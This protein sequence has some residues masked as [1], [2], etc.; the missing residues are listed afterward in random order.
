MLII[1]KSKQQ[2]R[3]DDRAAYHKE[4][5][6]K[7]RGILNARTGRPGEQDPYPD[8]GDRYWSLSDEQVRNNQERLKE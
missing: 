7:K 3:L 5:E 4:L 1:T 8:L 2:R 6:S